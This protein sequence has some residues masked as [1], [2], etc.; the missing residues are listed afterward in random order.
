MLSPLKRVKKSILNCFAVWFSCIVAYQP[1]TTCILHT[2]S[3]E[4]NLTW[5][6]DHRVSERSKGMHAS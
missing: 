2:H 3:S 4:E 1:S 6:G 5:T